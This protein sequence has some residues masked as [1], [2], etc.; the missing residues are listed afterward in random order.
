MGNI[1]SLNSKVA[2]TNS[3]PLL[4]GNLTTP[5]DTTTS[6][7]F[8]TIASS[9]N[10]VADAISLSASCSGAPTNGFGT[11]IDIQ[12]PDSANTQNQAGLVEARLLVATHNS[13]TTQF[14]FK[15]INTS[16]GAYNT[17]LQVDSGAITS[18]GAITT[19]VFTNWT[20]VVA[21]GTVAGL[22]TYTVQVGRVIKISNFAY[23]TATVTWT[24]H[25][26]TGS[27]L[28][29][30]LPYTCANI[31]NLQTPFAVFSSS[32]TWTKFQ[33]IAYAFKNS[34]TVFMQSTQSASTFADIAMQTSGS[35]T[36]SGVYQTT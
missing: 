20:P 36:I 7:C 10:A 30:T 32:V 22:G 17:A 31:N 12:C 11:G 15:N 26:G 6:A 1:N 8:S 27:L 21:G 3:Q 33:L 2:A 19:G 4:V 5:L 24:N 29:K 9:T 23:I 25:T 34:T 28:I 35:I 16:S 18:S 14:E 13:V